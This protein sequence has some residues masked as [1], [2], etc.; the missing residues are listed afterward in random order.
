[1]ILVLLLLLIVSN[2]KVHVSEL[3]VKLFV[4]SDEN[5]LYLFKCL[6]N[7]RKGSLDEIKL[8]G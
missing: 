3:T 2:K 6:I 7:H 8:T 4:F 1:M 5:T